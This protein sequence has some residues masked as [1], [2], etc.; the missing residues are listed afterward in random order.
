MEETNKTKQGMPISVLDRSNIL[1][2]YISHLCL[3]WCQWTLQKDS[4][5]W[6]PPSLA[7][8]QCN[9]AEPYQQ[10]PVRRSGKAE[11]ESLDKG[12]PQFGI[13]SVFMDQWLLKAVKQKAEEYRCY[14]KRKDGGVRCRWHGR[15]RNRMEEKCNDTFHQGTGSRNENKKYAANNLAYKKI[16]DNLCNTGLHLLQRPKAV[17]PS[18]IPPDALQTTASS[19]CEIKC[20]SLAAWDPEW[21]VSQKHSAGRWNINSPTSSRLL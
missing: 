17:A 13:P 3:T 14:N 19:K 1:M 16:E 21:S 7:E 8:Q 11:S 5:A 20:I 12:L 2:Q 9:T 6:P 15:K 4:K 18:A 10:P